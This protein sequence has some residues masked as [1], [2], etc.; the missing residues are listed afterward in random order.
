MVENVIDIPEEGV[1]GGNISKV[2]SLPPIIPILLPK[3]SSPVSLVSEHSS[4]TSNVSKHN[5]APCS[6]EPHW[7]QYGVPIS[8]GQFSVEVVTNTISPLGPQ[9]LSLLS[10]EVSLTQTWP[11]VPIL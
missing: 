9:I 10:Y 11:K 6:T 2:S 5:V 1:E 3:A 7:T 4:G 8:D